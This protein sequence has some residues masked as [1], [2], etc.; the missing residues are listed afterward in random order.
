MASSSKSPLTS[1]NFWTGAVTIVAALIAFFALTPDWA[2]AD[3]LAE[4]SRRAIE[5]VQARNY[6]AL[7]TV[8]VNIGNIIYH[9]FFKNKQ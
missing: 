3:Q 4:E 9:L 6:V 5:A 7:F 2:A 8:V 1:S